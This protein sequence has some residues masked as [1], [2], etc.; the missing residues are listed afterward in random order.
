MPMNILLVR[1]M[2]FTENKRPIQNITEN[3]GQ[4]LT[5][6][7]NEQLKKLKEQYD[8]DINIFS[9]NILYEY[10][11]NY[12]VPTN[13]IE[14]YY[15]MKDTITFLKDNIEDYN[16]DFISFE[17]KQD[18][19]LNPLNRL[20]I[21]NLSKDII[22]NSTDI[23]QEL[24][25]VIDFNTFDL[26]SINDDKL[27]F[28]SLYKDLEKY[29][30]DNK[31]YQRIILD[32]NN[33]INHYKEYIDQYGMYFVNNNQMWQYA[34]NSGTLEKQNIESNNG[35]YNFM[36]NELVNIQFQ[37]NIEYQ[38]KNYSVLTLEEK[39]DSFVNNLKYYENNQFNLLNINYIYDDNRHNYSMFQN[40]K[41][42]LNFIYDS[43]TNNI[44]NIEQNVPTL[45][46]QC[47]EKNKISYWYMNNQNINYKISY[48]FF[49]QE[50][51]HR[52]FVYTLNHM[53]K[54]QKTIIDNNK[55]LG[56]INY[57]KQEIENEF[58]H[59][60]DVMK[61]KKLILDYKLKIERKG[62]DLKFEIILHS[63]RLDGK[64]YKAE[65]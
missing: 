51:K 52:Q 36:Q 53:F 46:I 24:N 8:V 55:L 6:E 20:Q 26:T 23:L 25:S 64:M 18:K 16:L 15:Q 57:N 35:Y 65:N 27:Q 4:Y 43:N 59:F 32:L 40:V 38:H 7:E 9:Q 11:D 62:E 49:L 42:N 47:L 58:V 19:Y 60:L 29:M 2:E 28:I 37:V 31:I 5:Y 17:Y 30:L 34:V 21:D 56:Q 41:D 39:I 54:N 10:N 45:D 48:N 3:V 22:I 63:N 50:I 33:S 14:R 12:Y 44:I 1:E 61:D 13:E